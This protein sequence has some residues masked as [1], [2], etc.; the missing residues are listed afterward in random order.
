MRV[1]NANSTEYNYSMYVLKRHWDIPLALDLVH[2]A[3]ILLVVYHKVSLA[4]LCFHVTL[5]LM[6]YDINFKKCANLL[7]WATYF[8]Y[9][10]QGSQR[11]VSKKSGNFA[12]CLMH[13]LPQA[14]DLPMHKRSQQGGTLFPVLSKVTKFFC[15]IE[16]KYWILGC[17]LV[18]LWWNV[19]KSLGLKHAKKS[20]RKVCSITKSLRSQTKDRKFATIS[21]AYVKCEHIELI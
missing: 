2:T 15:K 20:S 11:C 19:Q 12:K 21:W 8:Y 7:I 5:S 17:L 10:S 9:L 18:V 4:A 13:A 16:S 6:L 3:Y 14:I 1:S